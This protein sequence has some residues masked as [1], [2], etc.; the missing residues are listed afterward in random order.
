MVPALALIVSAVVLPPDAKTQLKLVADKLFSTVAQVRAIL[1]S[2]EGRERESIGSGVMVAPGLAVTTLHTVVQ[3]RQIEAFLPEHGNVEAR[4]VAS[5]PDLDL[6]LL[7]FAAD[8]AMPPPAP[9][10]AD[11]PAPGDVLIAMGAG[12]EEVT[13]IGVTVSA[14]RGKLFAL[15]SGRFLDSRYWGGPLYDSTGHL[16]GVSLTA[17]GE[18]RGAPAS[19]VR[20]LID[21]AVP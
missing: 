8:P 13:V 21:R 3:A 15:S 12:D 18:P 1:P 7:R 17:I 11:E 10:A 2:D 20:A 6:A 4:L 14:A 9:L 16:A 5:D 19:A